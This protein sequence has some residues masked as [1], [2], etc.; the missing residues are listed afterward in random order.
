MDVPLSISNATTKTPTPDTGLA[1]L[2]ML[3]RFHGVSASAEQL[4]H[5][6]GKSGS[7]FTHTEILLAARHLGLMAKSVKSAIKRLEHNPLPALLQSRDA[8][9]FI[10]AARDK[11]QWLIHDPYTERPQTLTTE[12]LAER[13]NG[14]IILIRSQAS[15]VGE[16]ARFDFT[17]FIPA[18]VKESLQNPP[19]TFGEMR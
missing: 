1:C 12:Q 13:W 9:F 16:L 4:A 19:L 10:L 3:A 17:W 5:Q 6:Y 15:I 14:Q 2:V 7:T 18:I 8:H 11:D